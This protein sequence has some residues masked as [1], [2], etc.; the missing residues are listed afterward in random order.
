MTN[1]S[2]SKVGRLM[3]DVLI[4][5]NFWYLYQSLDD[6]FYVVFLCQISENMLNFIFDLKKLFNMNWFVFQIQKLL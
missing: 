4:E 6:I 3:S 5:I 1:K 2:S